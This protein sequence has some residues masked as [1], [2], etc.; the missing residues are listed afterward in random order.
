M[1]NKLVISYFISFFL[2]VQLAFSQ[3]RE[4]TSKFQNA[5]H[6]AFTDNYSFPSDIV[7]G[8]ILQRLKQDGISSRTKK[9]V[10]SS[11]GVKYTRLSS[12]PIDLYFQIQ[13]LG[14]RGRDGSVVTVFI[15]KGKDNFIGNA[16]DPS[17]VQNTLQYLNNFQHDI[18]LYS[19]QQQ[20]KD[21][22]KSIDSK[23][24][25]YNKLLKDSKKMQD[26]RYS[27]QRNLSAETNVSK[28]DKIRKKIRKLDKG[29][30]N[31]Q[32]DIKNREG[33]L[34]QSKGQLS[35]LQKQLSQQMSQGK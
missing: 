31:K 24:K 22:Q 34:Q 3:A 28:Q 35:L 2:T 32:T 29:I 33:E 5:D 23:S 4:T 20:I 6:P 1:R 18:S 10:I 11:E 9:G 7:T 25:Q 14:K 12:E 26:K 15:S 21:Q 27:L 8:A 30:L 13:G 17:V 19:L 16:N